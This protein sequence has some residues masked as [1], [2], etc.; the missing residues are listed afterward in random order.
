MTDINTIK[1]IDRDEMVGLATEEYRRLFEFLRSLDDVD[2][3]R[4]TVCD[5]WTVRLM[6]AHLLGAAE[7]NASMFESMRQL[8]RGKKVAK[9]MGGEDI[10][11]INAVQVDDRRQL[12]PTELVDRLEATASKAV[13]GRK[14]TPGLVR[15][16]TVPTGVG[17]DMKMGH[18][19]DRVF[20]RD[21][22]MHRIDI[23]AATDRDLELTSNHDGRIVADVVLE[24]AQIHGEPFELVLDGP[25][26]GEY[27]YGKDG[28]R[29]E[30]DAIEFC[31]VL[32]GRL[33]KPMPLAVSVVF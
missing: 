1:P 3:E 8:R 7:S 26:G 31:L 17:Y 12:S 32:A 24:W 27:R 18:L 15:R 22:W 5:D 9:A 29:I 30:M 25:A 10:D 4:Q 13:A 14:R 33:D 6:V 23:A 16:I 28:P 21:Q 2:W 19:M 11:G 20:T